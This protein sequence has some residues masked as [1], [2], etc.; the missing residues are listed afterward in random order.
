MH[1][2]AMLTHSPLSAEQLTFLAET[3]QT[4]IFLDTALPD[5]DNRYS[6]LFIKPVKVVRADTLADV[7]ALLASLDACKDR[8]WQCGYIAYEAAF[9][10]DGPFAGMRQASP[11]GKCLPLGW[12]GVFE[13]PYIFDHVTGRWNAPLSFNRSGAARKAVVRSP[14]PELTPS[15]DLTAY[16]KKINAIKKHIAAGD[17]YQV[18]FTFDVNVKS[19]LRPPLFY[20]QL[21]AAQPTGYCAYLKNHSGHI[22]SF[23]PELFFRKTGNKI[24][25]KPMKGTAPRDYSFD[26]DR[27]AV[28]AL[29]TCAKNTAENIMIVD[30]LRNDLGRI[31]TTRSVKAKKLFEV[32]TH[33][34]VHQMVSTVE[35]T[36]APEVSLTDIVRALFPCGSVTGAPKLRTME[37]LREQEEGRRGVYCGMFGYVA[38]G[39]D[40]VFNVP[41]RTLQKACGQPAWKF[42][43]GSGVVWDSS[44]VAEWQECM[45]KCR[46]LGMAPLP[47]FEIF[48]SILWNGNR[49]VYLKSH[50]RR[51]RHSAEYF[52]FRAVASEI[53]A[54]V[55]KIQKTLNG[56]GD[57]KVHIFLDRRG[58]LR[59]DHVP[60]Q[61]GVLARPSVV[62][63][64]DTV[65]ERN[66]FLYH[67]TTYRDWYRLAVPTDGRDQ[68]FD[69][70]FTNTK[71][72][73]T[74]GARSNVFVR[75]RGVLYTPPVA[76]GLLPGILRSL[77]LQKG[78]CIEKRLSPD[79]LRKADA[80]YCGNSVR[81]LVEVFP[82]F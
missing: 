23:S 30:L 53:G 19:P 7:P 33:P 70:I 73:I 37:I 46:F 9:A 64:K 54:M 28:A 35:G 4:L 78:K 21:R 44:A 15:M 16:R 50:L 67:K 39:G 3:E 66:V 34:T 6:Y 52:G 27:A 74:E 55:N 63:A 75:K 22:L 60:L 42:R 41:I 25:V 36:L 81:G 47:S 72:E 13:K 71:G 5:I 82:D 10:L 45:D 48:E 26:R 31:C 77:F 17:T 8:Y 43:V 11:E 40:A 18:N 1:A 51:L 58:A 59:W 65:D 61:G 2:F 12:F 14:I 32:Q 24:T 57:Q 76:C 62:L 38:P 69:V 56:G 68:C 20:H 29:R 49:L 80:V 79:D